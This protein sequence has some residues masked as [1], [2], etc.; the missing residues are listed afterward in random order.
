LPSCYES[1][2]QIALLS[3]FRGDCELDDSVVGVIGLR[4]EPTA[5]SPLRWA[6]H[7]ADLDNLSRL[8]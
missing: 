6:G 7:F 2:V 4:G 3:N 1:G 8:A 5:G